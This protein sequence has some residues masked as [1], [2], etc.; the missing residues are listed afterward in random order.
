MVLDKL[1]FAAQG[2]FLLDFRAGSWSLPVVL[3]SYSTDGNMPLRDVLR[4]MASH[5]ALEVC[6][7]TYKRYRVSTPRMSPKSHN[8]EFVAIVD[9]SKK[10]S[11]S[12]AD[13][14]AEAIEN[15]EYEALNK[16]VGDDDQLPLFAS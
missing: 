5:G 16:G 13:E 10:A 14:I 2:A 4:A 15:Q 8:V 7:E 12:R 3:S 11:I 1:I 6:T 9:T